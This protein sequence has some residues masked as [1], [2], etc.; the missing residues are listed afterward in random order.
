M[1]VCIVFVNKRDK[2]PE[3]ALQDTILR[4]LNPLFVLQ[5]RKR[6]TASRVLRAYPENN[7]SRLHL[8]KRW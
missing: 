8:L 2:L 7:G 5:C 1:T 4:Q 3:I 6:L